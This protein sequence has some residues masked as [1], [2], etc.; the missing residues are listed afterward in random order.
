MLYR[1]KSIVF[2]TQVSECRADT[3]FYWDNHKRPTS[4]LSW[5]DHLCF[6]VGGL[7]AE[8][9]DLA[10]RV[11]ILPIIDLAEVLDE[12]LGGCVGESFRY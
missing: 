4:I 8:S 9:V 6:Y 12:D 1:P 5:L 3:I 10:V 2:V 7:E 11:T